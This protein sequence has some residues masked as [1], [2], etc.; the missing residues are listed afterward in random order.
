MFGLKSKAAKIIVRTA[1]Y[2]TLFGTALGGTVYMLPNAQPEIRVV[3]LEN[4][5]NGNDEVETEEARFMSKLLSTVTT[6]GLSAKLGLTVSFADKLEEA[7]LETIESGKMTGDLAIL[8]TLDHVEKMETE[9][10]I[11]AIRSCLEKKLGA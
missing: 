7:T 3:G 8:T 5:N 11:L 2:G 1:I 9:E 4:L 6:E 10:F